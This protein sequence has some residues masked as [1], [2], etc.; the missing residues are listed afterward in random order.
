MN[1]HVHIERLILDGLPLTRDQGAGVQAAVEMELS[2]LLGTGPGEISPEL[3]AGGAMP[4]VRAAALSLADTNCP[5]QI[6]HRIA[7]TLANTLATETSQP[8]S[9][10][11]GFHSFTPN[12]YK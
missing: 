7:R 3:R 11:G 2:R 12:S 6:G 9:R 1:L 10:H 8:P 5:T 4:S